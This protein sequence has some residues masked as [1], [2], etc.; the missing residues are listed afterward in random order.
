MGS[1]APLPGGRCFHIDYWSSSWEVCLV[2]P[3]SIII[4]SYLYRPLDV[5][6]D[7]NS[8]LLY[9]LTQVISALAI[10]NFLEAPGSLWHA[11]QCCVLCLCLCY[12]P[13]HVQLMSFLP[14]MRASHFSKEP[15]FFLLKN[16]FRKQDLGNQPFYLKL[17]IL[18]LF[19]S[20]IAPNLWNNKKIFPH[21]ILAFLISLVYIIPCESINFYY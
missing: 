4:D 12:T 14:W 20:K 17:M 9:F 21:L 2:S 6:L 1:F 19:I 11:P 15:W 18:F 16:G 3:I 7:Y 13:H 5:Y 8:V 10:G